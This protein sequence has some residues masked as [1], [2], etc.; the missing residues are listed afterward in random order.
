MH[1]GILTAFKTILNIPFRSFITSITMAQ[2]KFEYTKQFESERM[3]LP[4]CWIVIRIDGWNFTKF[5]DTHK[6]SKPNDLRALGLMNAAASAVMKEFKEIVLA[7]GQSDEYSFVFKKETES[8]NRRETKLL[9]YVNSLFSSAY[10]FNWS[11]YFEDVP[12]Q[13]PPAFD[14]RVVLYPSDKNIRDYL[15]WRQADVHINNLY[16]T[17]FWSLVQKQN[18]T[19]KEAQEILRGTL[20]AFKNEL[21]FSTFG[22]NYNNEPQIF[23]KGTTLI[24]KYVPDEGSKVKCI[25]TPIYDDII[26]DK[27]WEEHPEILESKKFKKI[28]DKICKEKK[29]INQ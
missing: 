22:I 16:N 3:C 6:F 26:G 13:Y 15:S 27:F 9:T 8:F 17:C 18:K 11:K 14:G 23:R 12:L 7:F 5:C 21:L 28:N 2:S 4:N 1:Q 29:K 20:S 19:T 24:R 25:I 10:V